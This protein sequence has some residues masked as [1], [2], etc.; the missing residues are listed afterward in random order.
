M[1]KSLANRFEL[2]IS[3]LGIKKMDFAKKIRFSQSYVSMVLNGTKT[4]PSGRFFDAV[5]RE[6]NVNPEWIKNGR[7]EMFVIPGLPA[8]SLDSEII[9]KIRLLPPDEQKMIEGIINAFLFK[10][11]TG[12][13][14]RRG[15]AVKK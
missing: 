15:R 10:T 9:A 12:K 5:C 7:G 1:K 3:D 4:N 2:L 11:M 6:F 13:E 14:K 8:Y